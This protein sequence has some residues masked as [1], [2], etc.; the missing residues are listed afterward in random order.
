MK[1]AIGADHRGYE[2]KEYLKNN[3]NNS[4]NIKWVDVG[5]HDIK[6]TDYPLYT[7]PVC[8]EVLQGSVQ[9]GILICGTGVGMAIAANRFSHIYAGIAWN[10]E[11]ARLNKE[12][13][14]VNILI[15]PADFITNELAVKI[16]QAW[17][18]AEFKGDRY[19]TRLDM[20][21]AIGQEDSIKSGCC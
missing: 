7:L 6:R 21:D 2:L 17:L 3:L 9:A 12:H 5:T 11:V 10:E 20:I 4:F 16:V 8:L 18:S 14:N 19:K 1:I 13:D 15:L